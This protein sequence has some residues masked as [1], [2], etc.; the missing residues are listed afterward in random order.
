MKITKSQI[1]Q[2][3]QEE[4]AKVLQDGIVPEKL[5]PV[6]VRVKTSPD[7]IKALDGSKHGKITGKKGLVKVE[8]W[9]DKSKESVT[10]SFGSGDSGFSKNLNKKYLKGP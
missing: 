10:V 3:I 1:K 6:S 8:D 5:K 4:L 9:D 7:A 2:I